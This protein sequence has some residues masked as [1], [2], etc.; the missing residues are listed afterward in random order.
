MTA[1]VFENHKGFLNGEGRLK[2]GLLMLQPDHSLLQFLIS[3]FSPSAISLHSFMV[4]IV[5]LTSD[6]NG[7]CSLS[8]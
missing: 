2:T 3:A 5:S 8:Q 1:V 7:G 6:S 4:F